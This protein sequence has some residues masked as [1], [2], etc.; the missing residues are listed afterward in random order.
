[1]GL[2]VERT[3]NL[4]ITAPIGVVQNLT[5][6]GVPDSSSEIHFN[7]KGTADGIA[8]NTNF[9][10]YILVRSLTSADSP[11]KIQDKSGVPS[12]KAW[13]A[14][15]TLQYANGDPVLDGDSLSLRAVA[16][17]RSDLIAEIPDGEIRD[18]ELK[19]KLPDSLVIHSNEVFLKVK[20]SAR[21]TINQEIYFTALEP[22]TAERSS[23]EVKGK[24]EGLILNSHFEI[25]AKLGD[26]ERKADLDKAIG[27]W[28]AIVA[29]EQE[30][31]DGAYIEISATAKL[32]NQTEDY[33]ACQPFLSKLKRKLVRRIRIDQ[34]AYRIAI[35]PYKEAYI[36]RKGY[37]DIVTI[38]ILE[39]IKLPSISN[40]GKDLRGIAISLDGLSAYVC[41]YTTDSIKIISTRDRTKDSFYAGRGCK[42][43]ALSYDNRFWLIIKENSVGVVNSDKNEYHEIN[44]PASASDVAFV[45]FTYKAYVPLANGD[46]LVFADV[47]KGIDYQNISTSQGEINSISITPDGKKACISLKEGKIAILDVLSNTIVASEIPVGGQPEGIAISPDSRI[48]LIANTVS[49]SPNNNKISALNLSSNPPAIIDTIK[50]DSGEA[51]PVDIA[52]TPDGKYAYVV[53]QGAESVTV[54]RMDLIKISP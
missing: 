14:S 4:K 46:I 37:G 11:W 33:Q 13:T 20:R 42:D 54:I 38:N 26:N 2:V 40:V 24:A 5:A 28:K 9:K 19:S 22:D 18:N 48:A 35:V 47:S 6:T 23:I 12:S 7:V 29:T 41:D 32:K 30:I 36:T 15:A 17:N 3:S 31:F 16:T 39:N 10:I 25:Y 49:H 8:S 43:I 34:N 1:M 21:L 27:E 52:I 44:S 51:L 45:P 53:N 50:V